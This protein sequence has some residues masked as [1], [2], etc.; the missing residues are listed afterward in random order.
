MANEL[1]LARERQA[2]EAEIGAFK[3]QAD[4]ENKATMSTNRPGGSLAE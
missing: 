1:I 2:M 3:A 4:A